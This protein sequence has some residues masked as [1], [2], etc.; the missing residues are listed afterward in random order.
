M[1]ASGGIYNYRRSSDHE[2]FDTVA[3]F[4][5][6]TGTLGPS[7][8][9]WGETTSGWYDVYEGVPIV[10]CREQGRV[11]LHIGECSWT[12]DDMTGVSWRGD[13]HES[14]LT[15]TAGADVIEFRYR[16][17]PVPGPSLALDTTPF[18][19]LEHWDIG[20][21]LTNVANSPERFKLLSNPMP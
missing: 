4:D 11:R 15:F 9:R 7:R 10:L 20:L 12:V 8:R 21:F 1:R 16:P 17:R 6:T 5:S 19:E 18:V 13:G 3:D 2:R 14:V